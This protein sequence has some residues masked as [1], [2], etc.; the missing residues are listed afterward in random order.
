MPHSG[1][2]RAVTPKQARAIYT[3]LREQKPFS[4]W[5]LPTADRIRFGVVDTGEIWGF[6]TT[7]GVRR[8]ILMS[9]RCR[10]FQLAMRVMAHE[11]VHLKQDM[12]GRLPMSDAQH[13]NGTFRRLA[14]QV[15]RELGLEPEHF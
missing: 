9:H 4:R 10:T 12:L 15:C 14:D 2:G 5:R 6:Y 11:M 3:C 8:A 1:V 13:H 7:N